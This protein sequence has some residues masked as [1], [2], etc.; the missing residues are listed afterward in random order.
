LTGELKEI[1]ERQRMFLQGFENTKLGLGHLNEQGHAVVASLLATKI[2]PL[3][4]DEKLVTDLTT[5]EQR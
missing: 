2:C 4:G 3:E 5:P 1:A